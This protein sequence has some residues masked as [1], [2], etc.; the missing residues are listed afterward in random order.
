MKI[1]ILALLISITFI[2]VYSQ[3]VIPVKSTDDLIE[4]QNCVKGKVV[5]YNFWATW[6]KPCV[7]EFPELIKLYNNYKDKDFVIVFISL[8]APEEL[9]TK[10]IPFLEK[11][12]VDFDSYYND[13]KNPEDLIDF[14]DKKWEGAI[15]STYIF[16]KEGVLSTKLVG[17]KNYEFFENEIKKLIN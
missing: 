17:S 11:Q 12:G 15:P 1:I 8:D 14:Y 9:K 2:N 5:L 6:C 16:S 4:I 13:F 10:V 3:T 7:A